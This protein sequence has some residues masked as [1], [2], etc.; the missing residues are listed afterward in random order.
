MKV[1]IKYLKIY[2]TCLKNALIREMEYRLN[3]IMWG[4]VMFVEYGT[5]VVFFD[6]IYANVDQVAGWTKYEFFFYLGFVQIIL[7][8][9]MIFIFPNLIG[10]PWKISGGELDFLLLKPVNTQFMISL[11]DVNYGNYASIIAGLILISYSLYNIKIKITFFCLF[12]TVVYPIFG[13]MIL[14]SI[15]LIM[16]TVSIWTKRSDFASNLYFNL[17]AFMRNPS[18]VYGNITRI[19][20]TYV[21][22]V[23]LICTTP[24]EV[25]LDK[26]TMETQIL[27]ILIGTGWFL[28]SIAFWR[29]SIKSYTSAGS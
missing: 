5:I 12:G 21:F 13:T 14:Y 7:T 3:F 25:F 15:F 22:P 11:K 17:W 26:G 9:F 16:D 4:L 27:T 6:T 29:L 23:I 18:S 20:L 8:A 2:R 24:V 10:L 19:I 28:G 1:I